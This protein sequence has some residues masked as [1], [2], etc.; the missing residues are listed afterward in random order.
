MRFITIILLIFHYSNIKSAIGAEHNLIVDTVKHSVRKKALPDPMQ[1]M[2]RHKDDFDDCV[3]T[4]RYSINQRLKRYPFSKAVKIIAVSYPTSYPKA[5]IQIDDPIRISDSLLKIRNDTLSK[6]GLHVKNGELNYASIK[7]IKVLNKAQIN[8]LTNIIYNTN[9]KV[10]DFNVYEKGEC[11][12]PRNAI[13]FFD[14]DGKVFDY[15][16]ICFEC[17]NTES[18]SNKITVG[19]LCT[20]KYEIL[21][22]YLISLGIKYGTINKN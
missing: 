17:L 2:K 6:E 19:T 10:K 16:E 7:E 20:Q 4:N 21:R 18:K 13:V 5:D 22:K 14:K 9:Y 15:L 11:F 8:K 3:F 12:D 1:L